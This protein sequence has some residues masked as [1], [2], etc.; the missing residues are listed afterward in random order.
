MGYFG[1]DRT[2]QHAQEVKRTKKG[3]FKKHIR[4]QTIGAYKAY[5]I[6]DQ[7]VKIF[8]NFRPRRIK[9]NT[10]HSFEAHVSVH[11]IKTL[12]QCKHNI[13]DCV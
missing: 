5:P 12:I 13:L 1:V 9:S 3:N 4:F 10:V 2:S 11:W 6:S 8:S 7:M